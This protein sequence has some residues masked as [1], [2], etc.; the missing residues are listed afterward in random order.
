VVSWTTVRVFLVLCFILGWA[1]ASIDFTNAFVQSTLSSPVWIHI[2]QGFHTKDTQNECL[3]LKRSLYGLRRSPKLFQATATKALTKLGF[4]QSKFDPCLLFRPGMMVV[5]YVDDFGIGAKDPTEIDGLVSDLCNLGFDLTKEDTFH[6]FL[7]IK[8]EKRADGSIKLTQ[9][10]L[11]DKNVKATGL[12]NCNPNFV[13]VTKP[14]GAD[15]MGA[16]MNEAWH[17]PSIVGMLLYLSTNTRPDI[18]FAV[19]QVARFS[20][21]PKQVHASAIKTIVRYLHSTRLDGMILN[22]TGK[23]DL[24]LYVDA[25]FCGLYKFDDHTDPTSARSRTGFLITLSGFPLMWHSKLQES[26]ALSTL[27]AEYTAFS[28]ALRSLLPIKR[29]IRECCIH[30]QLPTSFVS[31]LHS[32]VFEDNQGAYL[33]A[34]NHKLTDRTRYSLNK[35][36]WFWSFA[37]E[38]NFSKIS[39][40]DQKADYLTKA[41]VRQTFERNRDSVQGF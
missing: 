4:K 21:N 19:S 6:E 41:L 2:P 31:S 16:P 13:P 39:T 1:T 18:T 9:T 33:L 24:D 8:M 12:E 28:T 23:L 5:M 11:I 36:H 30:L 15:P 40:H 22:P 37:S 29:L 32:T 38:I 34:I 26:I 25:D 14:L 35:W 3:E 10:G 7:G 27:E 17:Y 20:H